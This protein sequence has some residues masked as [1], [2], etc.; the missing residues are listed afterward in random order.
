MGRG[1]RLGWVA[2][3]LRGLLLFVGGPWALQGWGHGG[4]SPTLA[5]KQDFLDLS[6]PEPGEP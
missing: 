4:Q 6:P 3:G 1:P 2:A 5:M